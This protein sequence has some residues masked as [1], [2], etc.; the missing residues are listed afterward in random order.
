MIQHRNPLHQLLSEK[1][2]FEFKNNSVG[3]FKFYYKILGNK[4]LLYL[5]LS[6]FISLL[7]GIGLA[8]FIPLLQS[9]GSQGSEA[10]GNASLGQLH[11]LTD[12]IKYMG[13][14]LNVMT[15]VGILMSIFIVKGIMKYIQ[16][17]YSAMLREIFLKKV[18]YSLINNLQGISY[19]AFLKLDAGKIQNV[20]TNEVTRLFL[21]MTSYFTAAQSFMMLLTYIVLAFL[22][23]YQF[24]LLVACG[25]I[26]SN[27]I[28]RKINSKTRRLSGAISQKASDFNGY[29][30]QCVNHF[31]YLKSTNTFSG[32]GQKMRNVINN[33]EKLNRR[34]GK[35]R[36]VS[37]SIKEPLIITIVSIVILV[38]VQL[39]GS[40]LSSIILSLLLFY[41]SLSFLV[42]LQNEW[43]SFIE[44]IGGM[45][46]VSDLQKSM[47]SL[48]EPIGHTMIPKIE[49]HI[50]FKDVSFSYGYK[51]IF[52]RMSIKIPAK[53]TIALI[54]E[55]GSGKT[56][57]ANM[58]TGLLTPI[59]GQILVDEVPL[60]E[61]N[62]AH[63][64]SKIGYI[65][66]EPVVF[67][68]TVFNNITFWA[69]PTPE[70]KKR[71]EEVLELALLKDF[72][73]G[74]PKKEQTSLGDN[75]ILISGGQKQRISIAR[76]LF[77]NVEVLILDEA[78]S[79]LDSETEKTIQENIENLHGSYTM[80]LIA[81][82]LS[83]I[84][85]ADIIY[86]LEGGKVTA[87]GS[88]DEMINTS[89]R[90]QKMVSLQAI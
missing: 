75:G 11:Y 13:L 89:S 71:F 2:N 12:F 48:Q 9:V 32:Y 86:L 7:D 69:E 4:M 83:T 55:S 49:Q 62:M 58:I 16:L 68:D 84:R 66:Q 85:Q 40:S 43:Q 41:R 34:I 5:M 24:A 28:Y 61:L 18:R 56:T 73:N 14:E 26:L 50:R 82:R 30:I 88:F 77:K 10:S 64:R 80:V 72:V 23:N 79:A 65:S 1:M 27:V 47:A 57:I 8:M 78:T 15:V 35:L 25:S 45:Q 3:Y 33:S 19:T 44:N 6:T 81:H 31:K 60:R 87:S 70:N 51:E 74:L 59:D 36:A 76:E 21:T 53:Q 42:S 39:F 38:Q 20:L 54:G 90:F 67:N 17:N 29:L 22:A 46:A 52:G 37:V 63:Y